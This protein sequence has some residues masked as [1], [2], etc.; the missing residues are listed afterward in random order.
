MTDMSSPDLLAAQV[1][2]GALVAIPAEQSFVS[3][4]M[5]RA[6]IRRGVKNLHLLCVPIGSLAV[7]MLV[8]SGCV[9]TVECAARRLKPKS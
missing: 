5:V 1:P 4:A 6:L 3:M 2:D 8:G 9:R 7:D